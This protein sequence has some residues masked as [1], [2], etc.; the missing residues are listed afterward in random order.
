MMLMK[1]VFVSGS[2]LQT[3]R[4][5]ESASYR[6]Q[7]CC[8]GWYDT[9]FSHLFF[10][11]FLL[12]ADFVK[13]F[14]GF[15]SPILH[16]L[17][18]FG[19]AARHVLKQYADN[20]VSRFK[21]IKV[22]RHHHHHH[23]DTVPFHWTSNNNQLLSVAMQVRFL[24]PVYPGQSLQTEMWKEGNR[25]HIQCKVRKQSPRMPW[26]VLLYFRI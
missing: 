18:S 24:K 4:R 21:A 25:I 22:K 15:K 11:L 1:N 26:A 13:L 7:F 10:L 2:A 5:L 20:D 14:S 8:H 3:E 9:L 16:G 6:P 19:F 17:C 23:T 12:R